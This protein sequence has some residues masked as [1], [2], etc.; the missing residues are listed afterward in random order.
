M[1]CLCILAYNEENTIKELLE[2]YLDYFDLVI[3]V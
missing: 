3:V 1:N 2:K